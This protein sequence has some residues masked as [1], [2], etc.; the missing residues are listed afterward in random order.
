MGWIDC[1]IEKLYHSISL[2]EKGAF[3]SA[4]V[5][6][7]AA[8]G[9][10]L[11]NR[12]S[13]HDN[14]HYAFDI[15]HPVNSFYDMSRWALPSVCNFSGE[16]SIPWLIG[17]IC[18]VMTGFSAAVVVKVL[19]IKSIFF[20]VLTGAMFAVFPSATGILTY[21]AMA[22]GYFIAVFL[23]AAAAKL[24]LSEKTG[25]IPAAVFCLTVSLGLYQAY[26]PICLCIICLYMMKQYMRGI[27]DVRYL[28]RKMIKTLMVCLSSILIYMEIAELCI[29]GNSRFHGQYG[30]P[31]EKIP[32]QISFSLQNILGFFFF[33]RYGVSP[34]WMAVISG[35]LLTAGIILFVWC[36][37]QTRR[38]WQDIAVIFCIGVSFLASTVFIYFMSYAADVHLLMIYSFVMWP[39]AIIML[40]DFAM[41]GFEK[42]LVTGRILPVVS[43]ICIMAMAWGYV[44]CA[45]RTYLK[46]Q[47]ADSELYAYS[48][49]LIERIENCDGYKNDMTVVFIGKPSVQKDNESLSKILWG[50]GGRDNRSIISGCL[51]Y[52]SNIL[53]LLSGVPA[54]GTGMGSYHLSGI[55]PLWRTF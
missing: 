40:A 50:G 10:M 24:I 55:C 28:F 3:V 14:L 5:F 41:E 11:V 13:N 16:W 38:R 2:Q 25:N 23:S 8:H 33:N 35:C 4:A 7:L 52:S 36:M 22:D 46:M 39:V 37:R 42:N 31:L 26:L 15:N 48:V 51:V 29:A 30:I 53:S 17:L 49:R 20:A 47:L 32:E 54:A 18:I 43:A 27:A 6:G 34:L 44:I 9:Y 19:D 1:K 45:N 21:M 12:I